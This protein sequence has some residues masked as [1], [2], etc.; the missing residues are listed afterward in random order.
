MDIVADESKGYV[1]LT[2][3]EKSELVNKL[4]AHCTTVV[5]GRR[6]SAKSQGQDI[7]QTLHHVGVE[8]SLIIPQYHYINFVSSYST[9]KPAAMSHVSHLPPT[10]VR[11]LLLCPDSFFATDVLSE[12]F[13]RTGLRMDAMDVGVRY[14]GFLLNN[15]KG[16]CI[17]GNWV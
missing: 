1:D 14:E 3:A 5:K 6:V 15:L 10:A 12:D 7:C 17:V 16:A 4:E 9:S 8:A 2:K 11:M 13:V